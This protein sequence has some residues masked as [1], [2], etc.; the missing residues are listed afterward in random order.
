MK[1][2]K[3]KL[4][5]GFDS[6]SGSDKQ[7]MVKAA[8]AALHGLDDSTVFVGILDDRPLDHARVAFLIQ[9][10]H[11]LLTDKPI[12]IPVPFGMELPKKLAAVAD[13]VVRYDPDRLE[14]LSNGIA[15]VL[16]EMGAKVH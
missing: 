7:R 9:L 8:E 6:L 4:K 14:T 2:K 3:P 5:T 13:H 11:C 10:G 15:A 16:N 1:R 12:I